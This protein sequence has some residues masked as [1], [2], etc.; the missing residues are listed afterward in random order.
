MNTIEQVQNALIDGSLLLAP[1]L[2]AEMRSQ[3][4]GEMSRLF[5]LKTII[6]LREPAIWLALREKSASDASTDRAYSRTSDGLEL[7]QLKSLIKRSEKLSRGLD[8]IIRN[9]V[10]EQFNQH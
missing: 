1:S 4:A 9:A 6:E 2:C 10:S 7:L 5:E 3:L 8:T